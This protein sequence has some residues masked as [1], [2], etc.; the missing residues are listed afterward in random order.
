MLRGGA[1]IIN[2]YLAAGLLDELELHI[3]PVLLGGDARLFDNPGGAEMKLAQ[4]RAVEA[5][6]VTHVK[7]T[8]VRG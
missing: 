2:Q 1:Q 7:Y 6:G 3:V 8:V 4:V 5:P